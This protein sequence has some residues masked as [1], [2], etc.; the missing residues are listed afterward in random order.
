MLSICAIVIYFES[1]IH[2]LQTELYVHK[3]GSLRN[4]DVSKKEILLITFVS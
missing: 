4:V 1:T 2:I 3:F